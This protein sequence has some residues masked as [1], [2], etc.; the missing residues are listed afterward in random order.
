MSKFS[1]CVVNDCGRNVENYD[2]NY[3][4]IMVKT[5]D[6]SVIIGKT[7]ICNFGRLSEYLKQ[8]SDKYITVYS[9]ET[10]ESAKKVTLINREYIIWASTWD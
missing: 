3:K 1:D 6:D 5:S 7:N 9:E 4:N 10:E 2:V 8:G